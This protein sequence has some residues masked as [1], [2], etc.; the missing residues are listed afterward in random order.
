[1][2]KILTSIFVL[3]I[4][5]SFTGCPKTEGKD[6]SKTTTDSNI[7]SIQVGGIVNSSKDGSKKKTETKKEEKEVL[8]SGILWTQAKSLKEAFVDT[9]YF[10]RFGI[11]CETP[12]IGLKTTAAGIAY[13]ANSVTAGNEFKPQFTFWYPKPPIGDT[14][15]DSTGK[16]ITVPKKID[17]A[18]KMDPY[19]KAVHNAGLQMRGHVLVWHSQTHEWFFTKDY[20]DEVK[21]DANGVPTNLADKETMTAR[22]EWYIKSV[23]EHVAQWEEKNG[24]AGSKTEK[25]S[26]KKHLVYCWDVV[27]E[28]CADDATKTNFLRGSTPNTKNKGPSDGGSRWFQ[29]YGDETFIVNAF[30]FANAYA[31]KDVQLVYN[32]YNCYLEWNQGWKT[33]AIKSLVK[34]IENAPAK[35]VNGKSVKPRLDVLGMQSHVGETYPTLAGYE[36]AVKTLLG[37]GYDIH[38]TEFDIASKK[39]VDEKLFANYFKLFMKYSKSKGTTINGHGIT[40]VTVWGI[41]DE[42]SW[43]SKGGSQY[44]LLFTKKNGKYYTKDCFTAITNLT[45]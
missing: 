1:M 39:K 18:A 45:K 15:T 27:N 37:L 14:F 23:L 8:E 42:N 38:V 10:E 7:T 20:E 25:E 5:V 34:A 22:Q 6:L 4:L 16:T 31:P 3:G 9:G 17:F 30:R 2:K 26:G 33:S 36:T 11:A 40:S 32:D 29:V 35:T 12:E 44:P 41:N 24:Y 43:I 28:A 13:H 19:L 21:V